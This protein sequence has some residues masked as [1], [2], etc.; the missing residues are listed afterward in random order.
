MVD[1]L[2]GFGQ[3]DAVVTRRTTNFKGET[4]KKYRLSFVWWNTDDDGNPDFNNASPNMV[5]KN[6]VYIKGAGYLIPKGNEFNDLA[7]SAPRPAIATVVCKW[8][9]DRQGNLDKAALKNGDYEVMTWIF[10]KDKYADLKDQ[11]TEFH[12][13]EHDVL[14]NC[15]DANFQKMAFSAKKGNL[16]RTLLEGGKPVGTEIMSQ[17]NALAAN[18][19]DAIGRSMT[20]DQVKEKLGMEVSSPTISGNDVGDLDDALEDCLDEL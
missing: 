19:Y 5:A 15:K 7:G 17:A 14:V 20:V 3:N 12:F 8:P 13:G 11:H 10:S 4:G 2:I 16:F 6:R 9:L 18:I 1:G